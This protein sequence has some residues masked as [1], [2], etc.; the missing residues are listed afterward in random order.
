MLGKRSASDVSAGTHQAGVRELDCPALGYKKGDTV[1]IS[2]AFES[3]G[4]SVLVT[5]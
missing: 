5:L 1:N 2:D 3:F 4:A